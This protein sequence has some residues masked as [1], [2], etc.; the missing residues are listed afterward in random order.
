MLFNSPALQ[1]YTF[2]EISEKYK[3]T[4]GKD[5]ILD[6]WEKKMLK[7]PVKLLENATPEQLADRELVILPLLLL[8]LLL[9]LLTIVILITTIIT[10]IIIMYNSHI[11]M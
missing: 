1:A 6:F 11:Y 10:I 8:L 4:Y 7:L 2:E 3:T 5:S 9:L